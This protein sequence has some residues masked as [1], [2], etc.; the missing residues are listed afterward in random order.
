MT[1]R[2]K[3]V[4]GGNVPSASAEAIKLGRPEFSGYDANGRLIVLRKPTTWQK[5]ELPRI[6]GAASINPG[7]MFQAQMMLHVKQ[8]G[9]DADIFFTTERELKNIVETLGDDGMDTVEELF[10]EHYMK[11]GEDAKAEIKN[12]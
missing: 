9:D 5:F 1:A 3:S 8:I 11:T 6:L 10:M 4:S 12:S 2:I 7:W